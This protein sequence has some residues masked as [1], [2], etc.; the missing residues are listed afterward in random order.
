MMGGIFPFRPE[1]GALKTFKARL[2]SLFQL[3]EIRVMQIMEN[4]QY[5]DIPKLRTPPNGEFLTLV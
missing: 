5:R 2:A 3:D 4:I 1:R